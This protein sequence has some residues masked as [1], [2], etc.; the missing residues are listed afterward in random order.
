MTYDPK[1]KAEEL[2]DGPFGPYKSMPWGVKEFIIPQYE[3][4]LREA[5]E[6][7][8]KSL[9]TLEEILDKGGYCRMHDTPFVECERHRLST[10]MC[11]VEWKTKP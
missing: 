8:Q 6:A 2:A 5:Y 3:S 9:L 7:G 10:R 1:K 11:D 4:A